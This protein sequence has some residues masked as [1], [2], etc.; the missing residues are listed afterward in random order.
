MQTQMEHW[1]GILAKAMSAD[2]TSGVWWQVITVKIIQRKSLISLRISIQALH[3][4]PYSSEVYNFSSEKQSS[5]ASP[6]PNICSNSSEVYGSSSVQKS[7]NAFKH[8]ICS[9]LQETSFKNLNFKAA[10]TASTQAVTSKSD[11]NGAKKRTEITADASDRN[12]PSTKLIQN[13]I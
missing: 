6:S 10:V 13:L 2:L 3:I 8:T 7:S 9:D 11:H 1:T 4:C 5:N 12:K